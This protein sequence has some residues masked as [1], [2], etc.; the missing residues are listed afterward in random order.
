MCKRRQNGKETGLI[1]KSWLDCNCLSPTW[2]SAPNAEF[3]CRSSIKLD[4][5]GYRKLCRTFITQSLKNMF[6]A[7]TILPAQYLSN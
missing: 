2:E 6:N 7:S 3:H 5:E 1:P 4:A